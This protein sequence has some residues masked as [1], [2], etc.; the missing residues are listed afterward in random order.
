MVSMLRYLHINELRIGAQVADPLLTM[1]PAWDLS[2]PIFFLIYAGLFTTIFL[3]LPQPH[4]LVIGMQVYILYAGMRTLSMWLLPLEAPIG[5][6]PLV[7][8]LMSWASTGAQFTKDLFF[9]GH[10]STMFIFYLVLPPGRAKSIYLVGF[11][12]MAV[13]LLFQ[14]IHYSVDVL[15]APFFCF[16]ALNIVLGVRKYFGL[17]ADLHNWQDAPVHLRKRAT[18]RFV[19]Q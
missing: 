17:D 2:F 8:P 16:G 15:A 14:H 10:T 1:L 12:I 19:N 4:R 11:V 6:V 13:S 7:D 18:S 5:L 3:L 9:S